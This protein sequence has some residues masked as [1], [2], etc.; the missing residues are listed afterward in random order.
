MWDITFKDGFF[1][2][3]KWIPGLWSHSPTNGGPGGR[4]DELQWYRPQNVSISNGILTLTAKREA[5]NGYTW[6]SGIVTTG[7]YGTVGDVKFKITRPEY[8]VESEIQVPVGVGTWSGFWAVAIYGEA[9]RPLKELDVLEQL[10]REPYRLYNTF[11]AP[12]SDSRKFDSLETLSTRFHL[13]GYRQ[14]IDG[15]GDRKSVV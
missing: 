8:Y 13:Y 5:Y 11:H 2:P 12:D 10:G 9:P 3:S 14:N 4:P 7:R 6:T 15:T 1:D